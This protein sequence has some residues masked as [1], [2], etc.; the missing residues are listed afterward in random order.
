M[1]KRILLLAGALALM[2]SPGVAQAQYQEGNFVAVS[3]TTVTLGQPITI[4]GCCF[5]GD[6][7]I[8]IFS[9][10]QRLGTATADANGT[11]TATVT[12]PTDIAPGEHTIT[13]TGQNAD[14]SGTLVLRFPITVLGA[15]AAD[16][17]TAGRLTGALPRTGAEAFPLAQGGLALILVGAGAVFSV[18]NRRNAN[19]PDDKVS[20]SA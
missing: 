13:A 17:D 19:R 10:P 16:T 18:R 12:V 4:S 14:G 1:I 7:V 20:V 5:V 15:G 8:D 2:A 3:D 6:V 11:F 9:T